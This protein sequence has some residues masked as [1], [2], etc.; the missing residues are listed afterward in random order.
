MSCGYGPDALVYKADDNTWSLRP[1]HD[2]AQDRVDIQFSDIDDGMDEDFVQHEIG[3]DA[4]RNGRVLDLKGNLLASG[5][6]YDEEYHELARPGGGTIYVEEIEIDARCDGFD[7]SF[8]GYVAS[9]PL[10]PGIRY[11]Q[12]ESDG[13][14]PAIRVKA[15]EAPGNGFGAIPGL[16]RDVHLRVGRG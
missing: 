11:W 6:I 8:V 4:N 7:G 15:V 1:G 2:P 9:E 5:P 12:S 16:G 13:P 3:E 10:V 14:A